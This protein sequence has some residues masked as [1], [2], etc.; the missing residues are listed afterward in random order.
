MAGFLTFG[1][2]TRMVLLM[3]SAD[4]L[5]STILSTTLETSVPQ[6]YQCFWKKKAWNPSGH[7]ALSVN[8]WK[9]ALLTSISSNGVVNISFIIGV[10][11]L[12]T[13]WRTR[14]GFCKI[15]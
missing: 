11:F 9:S 7:R 10:T 1:I 14:T 4:S 6:M 8:I 13:C 5:P 2:R 15:H 12:G 3:L